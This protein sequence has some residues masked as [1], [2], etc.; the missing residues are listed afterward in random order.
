MVLHP[1]LAELADFEASLVGFAGLS[2]V[3]VVSAA[4]RLFTMDEVS[5][6]FRFWLRELPV[7]PPFLV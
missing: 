2:S 1:A 5:V 4:G 3:P 6:L 7:A